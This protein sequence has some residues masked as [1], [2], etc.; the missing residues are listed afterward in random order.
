MILYYLLQ[1]YTKKPCKTNVYKAFGAFILRGAFAFIARAGRS[2]VLTT[3]ETIPK[4][5]GLLFGESQQELR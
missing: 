1:S 4:I 2:E 5:V 3:R